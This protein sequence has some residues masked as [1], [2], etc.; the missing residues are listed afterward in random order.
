M[1]TVAQRERAATS[2]TPRLLSRLQAAVYAGL[3]ATEFDTW[4]KRYRLRP[5][6][7]GRRLL[8]DRHRLDLI[9]DRLTDAED[10]DEPLTSD[11]NVWDNKA[12]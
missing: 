1:A 7:H 10:H 11:T 2:I 8:Y 9:I 3:S 12:L 6:R 5:I 4:A